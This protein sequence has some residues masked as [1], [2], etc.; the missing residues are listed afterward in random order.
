MAKIVALPAWLEALNQ[1]FSYQL[2]ALGAPGPNR[3]V[4]EQVRGHHFRL[5]GGPPGGRVS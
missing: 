3:H 4:A 1:D 2:T 5:A